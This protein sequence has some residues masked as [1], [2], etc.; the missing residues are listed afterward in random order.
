V[1]ADLL[2]AQ[3]AGPELTRFWLDRFQ[4]VSRILEGER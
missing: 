3:A 4:R 1:D 2:L